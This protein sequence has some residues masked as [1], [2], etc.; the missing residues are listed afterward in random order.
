MR[1]LPSLSVGALITHRFP[2]EQAPAAYALIDGG[3]P[4]AFGVVLDLSG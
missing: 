2:L 4:E 3:D 1:L